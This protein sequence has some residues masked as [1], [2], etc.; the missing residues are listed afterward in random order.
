MKC[1]LAAVWT[2]RTLLEAT[3]DSEVK[4]ELIDNTQRAADRGAFGIPTF[5]FGEEMFFGK[6]ASGNWKS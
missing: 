3:Q 5:F 1:L 2:A 4:R 6:S